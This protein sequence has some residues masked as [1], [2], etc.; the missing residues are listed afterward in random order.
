M[1]LVINRVIERMG[2]EEIEKL[3]GL[4]E[5]TSNIMQE[6]MDRFG[7]EYR[8]KTERQEHHYD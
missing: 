8:A 4:W 5:M 2:T 3:I 6:E 7:E 1:K